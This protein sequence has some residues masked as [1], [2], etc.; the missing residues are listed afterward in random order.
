[1]SSAEFLSHSGAFQEAAFVDV[2][3]NKTQGA[4]F[5]EKKTV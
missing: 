4:D 2:I 1:M 5:Q 3:N